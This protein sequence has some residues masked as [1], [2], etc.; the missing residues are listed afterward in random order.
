MAKKVVRK[1]TYYAL[2][3]LYNFLCLWGLVWQVGQ[4]SMIYFRYDIEKEINIFSPNKVLSKKYLHLCFRSNEIL[5][6]KN[7]GKIPTKDGM[8][9]ITELTIGE[10]FDI[11]TGLSNAL[12]LHQCSQTIEQFIVGSSYCYQIDCPHFSVDEKSFENVTIFH[13]FLGQ[14]LSE[15][16]QTSLVTHLY[17][18]DVQSPEVQVRSSRHTFARLQRPYIEMC[19]DYRAMNFSSS[20][21]AIIECENQMSLKNDLISKNFVNEKSDTKHQNKKIDYSGSDMSHTCSRK[22]QDLDCYETIYVT[23]ITISNIP[24][25]MSASFIMK[26]DNEPSTST[27]SY[28]RITL[29][30]FISSI[31]SAILIWIVLF[32]ILLNPI[33]H[34]LTTE[35]FGTVSP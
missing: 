28:P 20:Q 25:Q 31:F 13:A 33:R 3:T 6:G 12:P 29:T 18:K 22:Y 19:M 26:S 23:R 2:A 27:S 4:E 34:F 14:R 10:Q 16:D 32:S 21:N 8:K 35:S 9:S 11:Q 7:D 5:G 24:S 15:F 1:C 17:P 30:D